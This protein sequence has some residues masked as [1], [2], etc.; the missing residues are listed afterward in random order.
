MV[1]VV[2]IKK[3]KYVIY[4]FSF[5]LVCSILFLS[6]LLVLGVWLVV[7]T[8]N[9]GICEFEGIINLINNV[10]L[11]FI[12]VVMSQMIIIQLAWMDDTRQVRKLYPHFISE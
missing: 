10:V 1:D 4:S 11:V 5:S 8:M 6:L 9:C 7:T 2:P 12:I 3:G